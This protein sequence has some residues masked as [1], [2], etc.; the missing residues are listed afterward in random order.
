MNKKNL[1]LILART[2]KVILRCPN[3]SPG[4]ADSCGVGLNC[5]WV[6]TCNIPFTDKDW[7]IADA[8]IK[9]ME[10]KELSE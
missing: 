2:I 4:H 1:R 3:K 7:E 9:E 5:G 10:E 8:I 6:G